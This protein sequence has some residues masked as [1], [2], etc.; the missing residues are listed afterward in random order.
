MSSCSL[1]LNE[2]TTADDSIGANQKKRVY[3]RSISYRGRI[4]SAVNAW[5]GDDADV[6]AGLENRD[7]DAGDRGARASS[8]LRGGGGGGASASGFRLAFTARQDR[9]LAEVAARLLVTGKIG[10]NFGPKVLELC[11]IAAAAR[12]P[13]FPKGNWR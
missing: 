8:L 12:R 7:R 10:L 9:V 11:G 6:S 2:C 4:N 13:A 1:F 5:K 3:E